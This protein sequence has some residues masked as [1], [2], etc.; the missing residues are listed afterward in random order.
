MACHPPPLTSLLQALTAVTEA[1]GASLYEM[2]TS[3]YGSFVA[4]RLLCVLAGRDVAPQ[5]GK[6][7]AA[8]A[9]S[10]AA[11]AGGDPQQPAAQQQQQGARGGGNLAA[12][13]RSGEGGEGGPGGPAGADY[14]ALLDQLAGVV[15][16]DDWSGEE[17]Q[18]LSCDAFAG[19]FLQA[20]LRACTHNQ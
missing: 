17:M 13:L 10:A 4:R 9:D 16:G 11:G 19:P 7:A 12:K 8:G 3:K 1:A 5:P 20:L 2:A 15:L 6:K 18:R 14:P